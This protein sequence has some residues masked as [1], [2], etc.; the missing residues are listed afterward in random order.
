[1]KAT[2][3]Q[4]LKTGGFILGGLVLLFI[5]IFIIGKQKNLFNS[6][7]YLHARFKNVAGLQIGN[8]VRFAGINVGTVYDINIITDTSVQVDISLKKGVKKF[9]HKNAMATIGSDGLMGDKI[10]QISPGTDSAGMIADNDKIL[11]KEPVNMDQVMSKLTVIADNAQSLSGDLASIVH[12]VNNGE[13]SLGRLINNDKLAKNLEGTISST[14]ATVKSIKKSADGF[15]DNMEAVKHN[16]LLRG[17]FKKKEKK[18]VEDSIANAKKT[19]EPV[20]T[21]KPSKKS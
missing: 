21:K 5:A 7:F 4:R 3:S 10:I 6:T 17:Y 2:L 16:F 18:R 13:G 11:G 14:E 15:S 8:L 1:M 20:D 9:I 19:P 12:K